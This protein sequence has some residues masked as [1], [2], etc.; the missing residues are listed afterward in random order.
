MREASAR[1]AR[2]AC[3]AGGDRSAEKPFGLMTT[4]EISGDELVVHV[5]GW[6]KLWALTS[7][8][9]IPLSHVAGVDRAGDAVIIRAVAAPR[10]PK[11]A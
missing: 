6:D 11:S 8:L 9:R 4:I 10:S 1:A 5:Q 3:R 2:S 7:E